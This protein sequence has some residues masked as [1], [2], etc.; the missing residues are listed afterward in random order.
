M[1][2]QRYS[3]PAGRLQRYA[4]EIIG[5]AILTEVLP[6]AC[7][8]IKMPK[9]KS[10]TLVVRSWVPWGGTASAPNVFNFTAESHITSEGVTPAAD[11]LT[12][13]DVIFT[14]NQYAAL[15]S[16]TDKDYDLYE[17]DVE[18]A[19]KEQVGERM[20]VVREKALWAQMRA[21]TN[22]F[23]SGGTTRLTVDET[24]TEKF[25]SKIIRSL[26]S[27]HGKFITEILSPSNAVSTTY[28]EAAFIAYVHTDLEYDVERLP[29]FRP[30]AAY[31]S[32]KVISP[33]ELGTAGAVRYIISPELSGYTDAGATAS[34]TGLKTSGT[35]VDV[36][37]IVVMAKEAFAQVML[38]GKEALEAT[39]VPVGQKDSGDP[40]GQRGYIGAKFW[41]TSGVLNSGWM[42]VGEVGAT[43]L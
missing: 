41:H 18:A 42:A 14:L 11:T 28:V 24:I 12:P 20:G 35:K 26:K 40:L 37:P 8:Q 13:R 7:K 19:M 31:G 32:R 43:D 6:G 29:N 5:H 25:M 15:Y 23:Y 17:D 33:L 21:C 4:G 27:S 10:D 38:R 36:Y 22:K 39:Y 2:I 3:D 9:N 1:S 30:V 16:L 34:G